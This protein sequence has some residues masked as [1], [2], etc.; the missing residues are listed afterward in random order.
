MRITVSISK[1]FSTFLCLAAFFT[2]K[3]QQKTL[4][5]FIDAA[6]QNSPLLKDY[7]NQ[8]LINLIDSARTRAGYKPQINGKSTNLYAPVVGGWGYDE[9]I[10][11]IGNFSE[12]I[13]LDKQ[14]INKKVL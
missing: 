6:L 4:D 5:Y 8:V 14:L 10:T 12:L 7:N 11:N 2:A 1:I 9:A 13:T 3:A